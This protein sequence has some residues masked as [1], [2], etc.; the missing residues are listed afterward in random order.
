MN[1]L[2]L[3]TYLSL[4]LLAGAARAGDEFV[5]NTNDSGPGSLRAALA[6]AAA[7]GVPDTITCSGALAG[8]VIDLLTPLVAT[9]NGTMTIEGPTGGN[10]ILSGRGANQV[11]DIS[12][13]APVTPTS[14][15]Y[16]FTINRL[17]FRQGVSFSPGA[18]IRIGEDFRATFNHCRFEDNFTDDASGGAMNFKGDRLDMSHCVFLRNQATVSGA[19][20]FA[21]GGAIRIDNTSSSLNR[22]AVFFDCTFSENEAASRGGAIFYLANHSDQINF[23][24]CSFRENQAGADGGAL[25]L[26]G[27]PADFGVGKCLFDSNLSSTNGGAIF[28]NSNAPAGSNDIS[29]STFT[30]NHAHEEGGAIHIPSSA[31][32][33]VIDHCTIYDNV[34]GQPGQLVGDGGG[35]FIGDLSTPTTMTR[36]NR[37]LILENFSHST[38]GAEHD[39]RGRVLTSTYNIV[40]LPTSSTAGFDFTP[41]GTDESF[42]TLGVTTATEIIDTTL[43]DNGG[44]TQTHLPVLGGRAQDSGGLTLRPGGDQRDAIIAGPE[45]D[46]GAVELQLHP[47]PLWAEMSGLLEAGFGLDPDGDGR[48]NGVEWKDGT[49]PTIADEPATPDTLVQDASGTT[50]QFAARLDFPLDL[51]SVETSI[52]LGTDTPWKKLTTAPTLIGSTPSG[53]RLLSLLV[54]N[55]GKP[56]NFA[57]VVINQP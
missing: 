33:L 9:P 53:G 7:D 15:D 50:L 24:Q 16:I 2:L 51:I 32:N 38:I 40:S 28:A 13:P 11:F 1:K 25:Y 39:V 45:V 19:V 54:S 23:S 21:H 49:D 46:I 35:V 34:A 8:Q 44:P 43:A 6:A 29:N 57:R 55:P 27:T 48:P 36:I 4:A 47:Y 20:G 17:T 18:G 10:L 56:K 5:Y 30:A 26:Q 14:S 12:S 3:H 52:D 37:S 41:S 22:R 42:A 31:R